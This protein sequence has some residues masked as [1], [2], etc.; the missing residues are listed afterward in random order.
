MRPAV[1]LLL[2]MLLLSLSLPTPALGQVQV[3]DAELDTPEHVPRA[4]L[5]ITPFIGWRAPIAQDRREAVIVPGALVPL[6]VELETRH[7]GSGVAGLEAE[8]RLFGPV[9]L[10]GAVAYS[11][12]DNRILS[13]ETPAGTFTQVSIRGPAVWFGRAGLS[14]RLP[15]P[16]PDARRYR[17]AG[18]VMFGPALVRE[19]YGQTTLAL[20]DSPDRVDNWALHMG[21]R[22]VFPVGA[23]GVYLLLSFENF[24]TFWDPEDP[25]RARIERAMELQPGTLL[26]A[27]LGANRTHL[28]MASF[29]LSLRL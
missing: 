1:K 10:A 14:L 5:S 29:G 16:V 19:D 4:R 11:N 12:P 9:A 27:S 2:P 13:A 17:P 26:N 8:L 7:V 25:E 18:F 23:R 6:A 15:E 20:P 3:P 22:G 24:A 28:L 21:A